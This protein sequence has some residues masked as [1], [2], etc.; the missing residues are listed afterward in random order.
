ARALRPLLHLRR[1]R[2][3]ELL[4]R[5]VPLAA[6]LAL[7]QRELRAPYVA[8]HWYVLESLAR[9]PDRGIPARIPRD[10]LLLPPLVLPR[11]L[12]VAA[13]V[14]CP[15]CAQGLRGRNALSVPHPEPS[16]VRA[17]LRDGAAHLPV[18]GRVR[19]L[20]LQRPL[21]RRLRLDP[22][23]RQRRTS[24]RLLAQLSLP[25]LSRRRISRLV[26]WKVAAVPA[27]ELGQYPERAPRALGVDE[28]HRRRLH[29]PVHPPS[30][31]GRTHRPADRV[32][33]VD[34]ERHDYDVVVIG[35]GGAGLRAAIEVIRTLQDHA[36][37]SGIDVF[38]E[39]T[40][41][42]LITDGQ[43]VTGAIGY[44]RQSGGLIAFGAKAVVLATGG[45]GK[46]WK[47]TSNSWEYTGDGIAM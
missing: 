11:V 28:P 24:L 27:L 32:L 4:L 29:R 13:G 37:A 22:H 45:V 18:V 31:D 30:G 38:M 44:W 20:Q 33:A 14:R 16:P 47:V 19:S 17:H 12:L 9:D 7:P 5:P 2:R 21:R 23:A 41:R 34:V 42:H 36:V 43:R 1:A 46:A 8:A 39:C 6:L 3:D 15:R 25:S 10:L 40:L 35:A 26:P